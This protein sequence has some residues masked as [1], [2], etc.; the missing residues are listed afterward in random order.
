MPGGR[1]ASA[2]VGMAFVAI[3]GRACG[4]RFITALR[5]MRSPATQKSGVPRTAS[6]QSDGRAVYAAA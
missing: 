2:L 6:R 1:Q 4:G 3:G 5:E